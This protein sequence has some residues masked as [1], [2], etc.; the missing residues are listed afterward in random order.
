MSIADRNRAQQLLSECNGRGVSSIEC[1][2]LHLEIVFEDRSSFITQSAWRLFLRGNLLMGN[3]DQAS[4]E[5]LSHLQGL[6]VVS[7]SISDHWDTRLVFEK[8]YVLEVI[9]N[10]VRYEA[11][12]AHLDTGL[13]VFAPGGTTVF[14]PSAPP[15]AAPE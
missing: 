10:S 6:K 13:V 14:P 15:N 12:E 9:C 5:L 8:D 11:W 2:K 3:N 1:D 4:E 7:N